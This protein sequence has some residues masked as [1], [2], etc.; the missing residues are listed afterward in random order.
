MEWRTL[1]GVSA[2]RKRKRPRDTS[3]S[4]LFSD[5][6]APP[7]ADD[8]VQLKAVRHP[9]WTEQKAKLISRYLKLFTFVTRHGTYIDGFAGQQSDKAAEGWA[10]DLVLAQRPWRLRRYYLCDAGRAQVEGLEALKARQPPRNK[11]KDSK[12][13]IEVMHGDFNVLVNKILTEKK[14]DVATFC[15]LDQRTFECKW[16]TVEALAR[17]RSTGNK[18]ELF[19]FLPIGWLN[20]A[21]IA[22]STA[23]GLADIE[24]WWGR[25]DW[26]DLIDMRSNEKALAFRKRFVELSYK[27]VWPFPIVD[28]ENGNRIMFYMILATDHPG[29]PK[30][31]WRAYDQALPDQPDWI[32]QELDG[33]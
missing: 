3:T 9:V 6:P 19:Y 23:E 21:F 16:A 14:L 8:L 5:L 27:H 7:P 28:S 30:L 33:L 29:A 18:I 20:R 26:R 1:R 32:Q 25:R 17:H 11:K 2:E 24:Q 31:M 10:A 15:L 13:E 4:E 12:R 22:T